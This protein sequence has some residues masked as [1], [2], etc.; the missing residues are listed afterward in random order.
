MNER[1]EC[2]P[3]AY[4]YSIIGINFNALK[5]HVLG[6]R[7]VSDV[8]TVVSWQTLGANDLYQGPLTPTIVRFNNAYS[9]NLSQCEAYL[10]NRCYKWYCLHVIRGVCPMYSILV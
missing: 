3:S 5:W 2:R 8:P 9:L 4:E 1:D 10:V 6:W 7:R